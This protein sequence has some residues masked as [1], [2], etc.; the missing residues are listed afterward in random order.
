MI[1]N[2]SAYRP[3]PTQP[4]DEDLFI[5]AFF[6]RWEGSYLSKWASVMQA[7]IL[8]NNISIALNIL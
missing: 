4:W 2:S 8:I 3:I 7:Q 1:S 6:S 5:S